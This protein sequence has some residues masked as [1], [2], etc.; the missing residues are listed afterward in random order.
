MLMGSEALPAFDT[1]PPPTAPPLTLVD[2]G[3]DPHQAVPGSMNTPLG[4]GSPSRPASQLSR[5]ASRGE[6]LLQGALTPI[7]LVVSG[8]VDDVISDGSTSARSRRPG[9]LSAAATDRPVATPDV[10]DVSAV[11]VDPSSDGATSDRSRMPGSL[12]TAA[13]ARSVATPVSHVVAGLVEDAIFD[14]G[15]SGRPSTPGSLPATAITSPMPRLEQSQPATPG[16]RSAA[17]SVPGLNL[18]ERPATPGGMSTASNIEPSPQPAAVSLSASLSRR[19][20]PLAE[21][22]ALKSRDADVGSAGEEPADA[23]NDED[24]SLVGHMQLAA[25]VRD[26]NASQAGTEAPEGMDLASVKSDDVVQPDDGS[27]Q[28]P[29]GG[30]TEPALSGSN[31]QEYADAAR[32]DQLQSPPENLASAVPGAELMHALSGYLEQQTAAE[33][34]PASF[35]PDQDA[36][37]EADGEA[38]S[39]VPAAAGSMTGL[40]AAVIA[41]LSGDSSVPS[42]TDVRTLSMSDLE[43]AGQARTALGVAANS[44]EAANVAQSRTEDADEPADTALDADADADAE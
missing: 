41:E 4:W 7:S 20:S 34:Q 28:Q 35:T 8:L 15:F 3:T 29:A 32:Q 37:G 42:E 9:S 10:Q 38:N 39:A 25:T 21:R 26:A 40:E 12:S 23:A 6:H 43:P 2:T 16:D 13:G 31:L 30:D 33:S 27:S 11:E 1:T 19:H 18:P 44:F 5:R 14:G 36:Q 22:L 24:T 17:P